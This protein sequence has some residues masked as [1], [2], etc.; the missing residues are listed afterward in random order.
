[1]N[2]IFHQIGRKLRE[3]F[4]YFCV[5]L[6]FFFFFVFVGMKKSSPSKSGIKNIDVDSGQW[7]EIVD[8][9]VLCKGNSL[10]ITATHA[11]CVQPNQI[12][13]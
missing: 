8:V 11:C 6:S 13:N 5:L 7:W 1:M 3:G 9:C 10:K 4:V 2:Q 12:P